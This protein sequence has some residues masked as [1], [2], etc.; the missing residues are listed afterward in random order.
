MGNAQAGLAN[1]VTD[2]KTTF[3]TFNSAV[4]NFTA[5]VSLLDNMNLKLLNDNQF[6]FSLNLGN[7]IGGIVLS[8]LILVMVPLYWLHE[9]P[10][11]FARTGILLSTPLLIIAFRAFRSSSKVD[12]DFLI[13]WLDDDMK[14]AAGW[15]LEDSRKLQC[16]K[17]S[18]REFADSLSNQRDTALAYQKRDN[19]K[20]N[21]FWRMSAED[22]CTRLRQVAD[23]SRETIE[24][25][26]KEHHNH[27][28]YWKQEYGVWCAKDAHTNELARNVFNDSVE[29]LNHLLKEVDGDTYHRNELWFNSAKDMRGRFEEIK[30]LKDKGGL[31]TTE[32]KKHVDHAEY[33]KAKYQQWTNED[34]VRKHE[35]ALEI[36]KKSSNE[37]QKA[38]KALQLEG[39]AAK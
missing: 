18:A 25:K 1:F 2:I 23:A 28:R 30:K 36:F 31:T 9:D 24:P 10:L 4:A 6:K 37:L 29:K 35:L 21:E 20:R 16:C 12:W 13:N 22:M 32:L 34:S 3:N 14:K 5:N 19:T 26:L 39:T 15:K 33:W 27:A 7:T 38:L 11:K 17:Q 8:V